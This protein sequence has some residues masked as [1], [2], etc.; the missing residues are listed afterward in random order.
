MTI[1]KM[2]N[3]IWQILRA[4]RL[5]FYRLQIIH[6][7]Q[8]KTI[9]CNNCLGGVISHNFGLR[10]CSPFVN[11]WIPTSHF[12]DMLKN[13]DTLANGSFVNITPNNNQYPIALLNSRWEIHFMHYK[14]YDEAC[15]KWSERV[16]RLDVDNMYIILVETHSSTYEDLMQFDKLPFRNK[17]ILAHKEYH[18]I[19]CSV[20]IE[21]YDGVGK[22]GEI[23]WPSN[24]WGKCKYD[25]IDWLK[26]LELK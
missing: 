9:V 1:A 11:L 13:I 25:S 2:K 3:K 22:N 18:N 6:Q 14:S 10:H 15:K 21:G 8:E 23:L 12:I 7:P 16:D 5:W 19:K 24:R 17:I 4:V 20:K 26:F